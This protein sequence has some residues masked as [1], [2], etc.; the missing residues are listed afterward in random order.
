[1]F[2]LKKS[3]D[4]VGMISTPNDKRA[5]GSVLENKNIKNKIIKPKTRSFMP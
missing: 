3:G 4:V 1:M 2:S 5:L